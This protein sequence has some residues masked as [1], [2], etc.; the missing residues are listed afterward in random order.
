MRET[1]VGLSIPDGSPVDRD[2]AMQMAVPRTSTDPGL[3]RLTKPSEAP[4]PAAR[5]SLELSGSHRRTNS[6]SMSNLSSIARR[7]RRS[8]GSDGTPF[9]S[10]GLKWVE[11][12]IM[13]SSDLDDRPAFTGAAH[14]A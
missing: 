6:S 3:I 11:R 8:D 10:V 7:A 12:K 4:R 1:T 14:F 2:N 13:Q 5:P 9:A